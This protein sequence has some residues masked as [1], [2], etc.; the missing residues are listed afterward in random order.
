VLDGDLAHREISWIARRKSAAYRECGCCYEAVRLG[1]RPATSGEIPP[2]L[3]GLPTFQGPQR[4][5]AEPG[6]QRASLANLARSESPNRL[7][8]VD[9]ARVRRVAAPSERQEPSTCVRPTAQE[10]DEGR[11]IEENRRQLTDAA[12]V[13]PPLVANPSRSILVPFMTAV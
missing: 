11:G 5:N 8:H 10:V 1:E 2:P 13:G 9:R 7:L 12:L 4:N 6:E 3:A